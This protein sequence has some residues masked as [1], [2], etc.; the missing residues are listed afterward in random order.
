VNSALA[1]GDPQELRFEADAFF[2]AF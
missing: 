2:E 1:V